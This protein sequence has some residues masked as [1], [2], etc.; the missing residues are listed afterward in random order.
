M[1]FLN[2]NKRGENSSTLEMAIK[3]YILE[4]VDLVTL[5]KQFSVK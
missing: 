1:S 5:I 4:L 3:S 2:A